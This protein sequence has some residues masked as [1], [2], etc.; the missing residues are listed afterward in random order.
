MQ[1]EASSK[2]HWVSSLSQSVLRAAVSTSLLTKSETASDFAVAPSTCLCPRCSINNVKTTVRFPSSHPVSDR[3][4]QDGEWK[5]CSSIIR[6]IVNRPTERV[7]SMAE[8]APG[9]L[10]LR[11]IT[12]D[13]AAP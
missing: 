5:A 4:L 10:D 7:V 13:Y 9:P 1:G 12:L 2:S 6:E 3:N 8:R 11:T